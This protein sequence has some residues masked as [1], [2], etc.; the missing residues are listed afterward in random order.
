MTSQ[1]SLKQTF[2]MFGGSAYLQIM[3]GEGEEEQYYL[4]VEKWIHDFPLYG[5]S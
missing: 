1:K 5:E 2:D 4:Y 3:E